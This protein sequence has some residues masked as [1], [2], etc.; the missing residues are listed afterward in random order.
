MVPDSESLHEPRTRETC[1]FCQ[2]VDAHALM[3]TAFCVYLRCGAC[4]QIW[5]VAER[6]ALPRATDHCRV[7]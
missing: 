5:T 4:N 1:P 3:R 7:F 6:R 2:T